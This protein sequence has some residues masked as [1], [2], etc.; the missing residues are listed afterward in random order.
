MNPNLATES[1]PQLSEQTAGDD[2]GKPSASEPEDGL[3][4]LHAKI[5]QLTLENDF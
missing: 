5:D 4:V 2:V 3:K 1:K